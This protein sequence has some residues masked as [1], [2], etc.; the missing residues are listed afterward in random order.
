MQDREILS[1]AEPDYL[2]SYDLLSVSQISEQIKDVVHS[3]RERVACYV[4]NESL[5]ANWE[6][7]RIIVENEQGG[8][9]RAKYGSGLIP[10]LSKE[11]TRDLGRGFSP[12]NLANMRLF[13]L[14][15]P[16]FQ[17]VSGKLS[18]SH[19]CDLINVK[20]S[21][22]RVFYEREAADSGWSVREMRRQIAT[23]LYER[24]LLAEGKVSKRKVLELA[25][26]GE[27]KETALFTIVFLRLMC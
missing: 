21:D 17:T 5:Q 23:S 27:D 12:S 15:N 11:L 3:A 6:I 19:H 20:N 16:I 25:A 7:G 9:V 10:A 26:S 14:M 18:W 2:N 22:A 24:V 13:Y 4:N 8:E 1:T